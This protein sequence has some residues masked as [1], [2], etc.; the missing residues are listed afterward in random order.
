MKGLI[1]LGGSELITTPTHPFLQEVRKELGKKSFLFAIKTISGLDYFIETSNES[2][3]LDWTSHVSMI[4]DTA[5]QRRASVMPNTLPNINTN[6]PSSNT[7]S[8]SSNETNTILDYN[9]TSNT[10]SQLVDLPSISNLSLEEASIKEEVKSSNNS[11]IVSENESVE[12][13]EITVS[14]VDSTK[15][16]SLED[17]LLLSIDKRKKI[18]VNTFNKKPKDVCQI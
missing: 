1:A 11:S 15:E 16:T 4:I 10:S 5:N 17:I 2:E 3:H 12:N 7:S 18:C 8:S 14:A 13:S 6:V 9:T